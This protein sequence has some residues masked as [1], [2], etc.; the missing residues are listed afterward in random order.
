MFL[1]W[2]VLEPTVQMK[3]MKVVGGPELAGTGL[4][5]LPCRCTDVG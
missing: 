5:T 2:R 1:L 3:M 4:D